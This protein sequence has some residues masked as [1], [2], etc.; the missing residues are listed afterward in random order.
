M[1]LHG[2]KKLLDIL[3]YKITDASLVDTEIHLYL[4]PYKKKKPLCPQCGEEHRGGYHSSQ[5]TEAEDLPI[6]GK[7]VTYGR[8]DIDV[9]G[10]EKYIPRTY[11]GSRN[12]HGLPG[13]L[14]N[15]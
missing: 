4:E 7:R 13:G 1:L 10:M 12:G 2:T 9:P 8:E 15:R 11:R 14:Q 3:G 6:S 5:W